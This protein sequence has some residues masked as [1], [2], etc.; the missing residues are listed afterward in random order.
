MV[1][2][3]KNGITNL[4]SYINIKGRPCIPDPSPFKVK[5]IALP[6][7]CFI[8]LTKLEKIERA[9]YFKA[10]NCTHSMLIQTYFSMQRQQTKAISFFIGTFWRTQQQVVFVMLMPLDT[11]VFD[12]GPRASV[13]KVAAADL[14]QFWPRPSL[15]QSSDGRT[16]ARKTIA[17]A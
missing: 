5:T 12:W 16:K 2:R 10:K 14:E 4:G 3:V 15:A 8:A 13:D 1:E 7:D 11:R 9:V 6:T 17:L